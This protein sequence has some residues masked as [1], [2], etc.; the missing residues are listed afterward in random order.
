MKKII[1]GK[2]NILI[3]LVNQRKDKTHQVLA[4]LLMGLLLSFP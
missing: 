1:K 4:G 2:T 3:Y